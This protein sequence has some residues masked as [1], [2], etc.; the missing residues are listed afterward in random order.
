MN[1]QESFI[2]QINI[3]KSRQIPTQ[4]MHRAKLA[5]LDYIG[6]TLA[7]YY[8]QRAKIEKL[9]DGFG[10]GDGSV[11]PVG[12]SVPMGINSAVFLN[13]LNGHALVFDDGTNAGIIHLG[14]PIFSV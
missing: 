5:F 9:I 6:V 7:G 4:V 12:I 13:G 8:E 2:D 11:Y 10:E 3:V 1:L 14:S